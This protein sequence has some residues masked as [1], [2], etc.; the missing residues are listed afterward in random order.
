MELNICIFL[1]SFK[2]FPCLSFRLRLLKEKPYTQKEAEMA[3]GMGSYTISPKIPEQN[4]QK[5]IQMD[6]NASTADESLMSP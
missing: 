2:A 1:F 6:S 5:I 4:L 3:A